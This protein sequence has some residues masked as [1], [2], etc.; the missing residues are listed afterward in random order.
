MKHEERRKPVGYDASQHSEKLHIYWSLE[1]HI[2]TV[3]V[4]LLVL[5]TEL[6]PLL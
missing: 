4:N 5:Y 1:M 2:F 6:L 3:H